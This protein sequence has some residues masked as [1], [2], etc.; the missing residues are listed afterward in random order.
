MKKDGGPA[1]PIP[2]EL[3]LDEDVAKGHVRP[4]R[5]E[6]GMSLRDYFAAAAMQGILAAPDYVFASTPDKP[7]GTYG[8]ISIAQEAY[9]YADAMLAERERSANV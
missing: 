7:D 1:F 8:E 3:A 4:A 2:F 9:I 5:L 6:T